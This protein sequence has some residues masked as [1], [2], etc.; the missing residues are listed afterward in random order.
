M[1]NSCRA[2]K[3]L[4]HYHSYAALSLQK[5]GERP[6]LMIKQGFLDYPCTHQSPPLPLTWY[7]GLSTFYY[8]SGV[9]IYPKSPILFIPQGRPTKKD[10]IPA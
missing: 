8:I 2:A 10:L 5:R 9:T 7:R 6:P 3:V 1:Y 4:K